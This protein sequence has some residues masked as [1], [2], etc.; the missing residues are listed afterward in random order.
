MRSQHAIVTL[1]GALKPKLIDSEAIGCCR[2]ARTDVRRD[3]GPDTCRS[4]Q[5]AVTRS[6]WNR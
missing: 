1:T 2:I 3:G 5:L 4:S 6:D